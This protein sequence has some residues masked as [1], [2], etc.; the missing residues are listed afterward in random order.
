MCFPIGNE[1]TEAAERKVNER[2]KELFGEDHRWLIEHIENGL[3][4][5]ADV[6]K[7]FGKII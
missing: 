2:Y 7:V 3:P 1:V 4:V 6:E 5:L